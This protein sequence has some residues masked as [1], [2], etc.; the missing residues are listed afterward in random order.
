M[1]L[2]LSG[3]LKI[4]GAIGA[5]VGAISGL[6]LGFEYT[7]RNFQTIDQARI[8]HIES[9]VD[10]HE[11]RLEEYQAVAEE[12]RDNSWNMRVGAHKERLKMHCDVLIKE[13]VNNRVCNNL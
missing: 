8:L 11:I 9:Q 2:T 5:T 4:A 3:Y 12:D 13:E 1:S 6:N 7:H 10:Y